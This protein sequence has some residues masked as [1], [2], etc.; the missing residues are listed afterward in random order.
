M[1]RVAQCVAKLYNTNAQKGANLLLGLSN[2]KFVN[3]RYLFATSLSYID[4][5]LFN[6]DLINK[7][8]TYLII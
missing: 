8:S 4:P 1:N 7:L 5:H 3:A 2:S 6:R